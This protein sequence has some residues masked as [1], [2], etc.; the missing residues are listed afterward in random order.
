MKQNNKQAP[1][2]TALM[3]PELY[4]HAVI[5]CQLIETH[6]SWVIL[7][8]DY[9]YK[10]KK[11]V[12]LGFLDFSTLEKRRFYC[13]EELRLNR[14]LAPAIYLDV[15][16]ICGTPEH[17]F[18]RGDGDI[19]E[20]AVKMVQFPQDAQLDRVLARGDLQFKKID[21]I[22]RMVAAFHQQ[23]NVADRDSPYGGPE[24]VYQ[25]VMENFSQIH[26][27][28]SEKVHLKTLLQLQRWCESAYASL[29]PVLLQRKVEGYIRECHGDMHLRNLAWHNGAPLAFD[30]LEFNANLRWIDVIS[31]VAFLVMDLHDHQQGQLAQRFLNAYL[32]QTGDYGAIQVLRFYLVYRAM[33]RAK[34]DAIRAGQSGINPQERDDAL[35]DF[36]GYLHLATR[37]TRVDKPR[38]I[39]TRGLSASGKTTETQPL[40]ELMEAIRVRSD[41]ERKRIYDIRPEQSTESETG[42]G[43]Y[44]AEATQ[45]TYARLVELAGWVID[46]GYSVIID[47][48]NLKQEQR[49]LFQ[50]LAS[51]K[52][53]A[54][55]ILEFT[56]SADT[57]RKRIMER[58]HDASDANLKVLEHQLEHWQ[59]LSESEQA[60]AIN[61]DTEVTYN[62]VALLEKI[63]S[64]T[65]G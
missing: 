3:D 63:R 47:A 31:E 44:T 38:L 1:L 4:D 34:V 56:A 26:E 41:V 59:P 11:P 19:I 51:Q 21:A 22:A 39:I 10:I 49:L 57:L 36:S 15:V 53:V 58:K 20:Y 13:Q 2:I 25:P 45:Q 27:R 28:I 55:I 17:P 32:E 43:I 8:G 52:R 9:A 62:V 12:N 48:A 24:Q 64:M 50:Q 7:T 16:G 46:A 5:Q 6:I 33:V 35:K 30:C 60:Y 54:Y 42:K 18:L 29:R 23:I 40:L 65:D 61:I 14:R 37:Y